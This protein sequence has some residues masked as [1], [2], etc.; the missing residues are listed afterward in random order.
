MND[1]FL[2][3]Q[4]K[5][6]IFFIFDLKRLGDSVFLISKGLFFQISGPLK[7][8]VLILYFIVDLCLGASII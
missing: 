8:I 5:R 4:G 6:C 1:K 2:Q 3:R 7:A